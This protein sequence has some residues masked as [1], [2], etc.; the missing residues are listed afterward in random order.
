[1]SDPLSH[2]LDQVISAGLL[3]TSIEVDGRMRRVDVEGQK[4]GKKAGWYVAHWMRLDDGREVV[5]G[6]Y[7]IWAGTENQSHKF[8]VAK[9]SWSAADRARFKEQ[10]R[11]AAKA[12]EEARA[13]LNREAAA[14]ST[15]IWDKLSD[16]G[17]SPYLVRKH[18]SSYGLRYGRDGTVA[19]PLRN[20]AGLIVGL[21]F[22]QADGS[23]KFI[24]GTA[25]QG[26]WFLIG[27]I[28]PGKPIVLVEGYATGASVHEATGLAVLVCFDAGNLMHVAK[29]IRQLHTQH[30][31][32]VAG[33]DDH[34][35][36]ENAGRTQALRVAETVGGI[37]AF[38]AFKDPN[39]RTDWN[40]LHDEQG[41]DVVREQLRAAWVEHA[42]Q[43]AAAAQESNRDSW[44][45]ELVVGPKG[46]IAMVH[47]VRTIL[48]YHRE[49]EGV[50]AFDLFSKKLVK[51]K[52]APYGGDIG[53]LTDWDEIETAAWFGRRDTY[54]LQV[55]TG[56]AHEAVIAVS[57]RHP[58]HPLRDYLEGLKWDGTKRLAFFFK[59][60]CGTEQTILTER[61]ALNFFIGCVARVFR[62][63][64]KAD[65]ML[66]IEGEQGSRKSTLAAVLA[67]EEY[68]V[69]LGATPADKDFYQIIQGKWIVEISE[70]AA[71]A[72][73]ESSHIKRAVSVAID[74][75]RPSYGRNAESFPRQ[76][77]FFGTVNNSDWQRDETGGRRYMPV[78][79]QDIQIEAIRL[80]RDQLWAEAVALFKA[81]ETWHEL[82]P[83]ARDAQEARYLEDV[84]AEPIVRWLEGKGKTESYGGPAGPIKVT[85]AGEI[86]L[87]ALDL[88]SKKQDRVA[89]MRVGNLMRR[90]GW[91]RKQKRVGRTQVWTYRR[92]D[93]AT[94]VPAV[95]SGS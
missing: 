27:A 8:A 49:W 86:L 91:I 57:H 31:I 84:W 56:I 48:D 10:Q 46:L 51:R 83:E 52:P 69:D 12:S 61:F 42:R 34:Q 45:A 15:Q 28:Q 94:S 43:E 35:K 7:G 18:V 63:G 88:D 1:M 40:D 30:R 93:P 68:F 73:A 2:A 72:K 20:V 13:E 38:P 24:T 65:L 54:A 60:Y 74:H 62:P 41:L 59:D 89:Q 95:E 14:R 71:F 5:V 70:L 77:L 29:A 32:L 92:P 37:A 21:Q 79:V 9:T 11:A 3:V 75:F 4:K 36:P 64:C 26:A 17:R 58:F 19:I 87:R 82:P 16:N 44:Q 81:G 85:T 90:L 23:K 25:K 53:A 50:L 67:G 80:V 78:W 55:P 76:C 6:A 33:D 39:G 47:N 22:I 66:V